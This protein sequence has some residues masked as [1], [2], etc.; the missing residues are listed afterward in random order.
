PRLFNTDISLIKA[1]PITEHVR[2]N[3][4]AEM[5]NAFNHPNFNFTDSYSGGT[6]NPAQYLLVNSAPYAP[7]TVGQNGNRQIQ[8]R[9][10]V[11][12]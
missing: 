1:I 7:G 10:Q 6:N 8:F 3:I 4:Y 9:M 5:L 2:M 12:F 11:A